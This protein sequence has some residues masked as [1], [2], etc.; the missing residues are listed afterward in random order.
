MAFTNATRLA[1]FGRVDASLLARLRAV[2]G[3]GNVATPE[4]GAVDWMERYEAQGPTHTHVRPGTTE[5]VAG[6][7]RACHDADV[8]MVPRGGN[9]GLVGGATPVFDEVLIDLGRLNQ[10]EGLDPHSGVAVGAYC[11]PVCVFSLGVGTDSP[12]CLLCY[13]SLC[14][15]FLYP[16]VLWFVSLPRHHHHLSSLSLYLLQPKAE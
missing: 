12:L 5:E 6:V 10:F 2:V 8:A 14:S 4:R 7:V 13:I 16:C 1:A 3:A 9:T 15:L 11:S